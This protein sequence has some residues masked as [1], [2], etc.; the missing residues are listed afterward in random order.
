MFLIDSL[1]QIG[2]A[3][4]ILKKLLGSVANNIQIESPFRCDYGKNI[5]VGD[6]FYYDCIIRSKN[7]QQLMLC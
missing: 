6:N 3:V 7:R 5:R 1:I 2:A 4:S